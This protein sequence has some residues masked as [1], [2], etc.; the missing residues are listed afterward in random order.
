MKITELQ[1]YKKYITKFDLANMFNIYNDPKLG[2]DYKSYNLNRSI[3]ITGI[4]QLPATEISTYTVKSGDT[5]NLISYQLYGTIQL[6]WLIAKL[7]NINDATIVLRPGWV[8]YTLN[9]SVVNN[10]LNIIKT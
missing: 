9:S 6:W 3:I 5:L 4:N 7:N 1:N 10:I 2:P 8:L